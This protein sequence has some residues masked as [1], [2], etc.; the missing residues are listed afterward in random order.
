MGEFCKLLLNRLC[1]KLLAF[2]NLQLEE[3]FKL[4]DPEFLKFQIAPD[5]LVNDSASC[6]P[7]IASSNHFKIQ[8]PTP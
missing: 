6:Q 3:L 5:I 1:N 8:L 7:L 4:F 2:G